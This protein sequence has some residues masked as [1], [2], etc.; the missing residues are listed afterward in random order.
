M[1]SKI[2]GVVNS[3][4]ILLYSYGG[5]KLVQDFFNTKIELKDLDFRLLSNIISK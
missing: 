3:S 1:N 2:I 4:I 5:Y